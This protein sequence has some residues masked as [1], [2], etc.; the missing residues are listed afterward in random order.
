MYVDN[1]H[2]E[3]HNNKSLESLINHTWHLPTN[4]GCQG[5][6]GMQAA[7]PLLTTHPQ[8][9]WKYKS[10]PSLLIPSE[11]FEQAYILWWLN[12]LWSATGALEQAIKTYAWLGRCYNVLR[13][14]VFIHLTT[15]GHKQLSHWMAVIF[16]YMYS[17]RK[18]AM[19]VLCISHMIEWKCVTKI[20]WL[21]PNGMGVW[22][23]LEMLL[24]TFWP[25]LSIYLRD[26]RSG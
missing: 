17:I 1:N 5:F 3:V 19:R 6:A 15:T 18:T 20:M 16:F 12:D 8:K 26:E 4:M 9:Q 13:G 10:V 23:F 14:L 7:M 22:H 11:G 2:K 24:F 25:Y 21:M